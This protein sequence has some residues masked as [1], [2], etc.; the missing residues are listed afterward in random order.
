MA[1]PVSLS[2]V[3]SHVPAAVH[4][5][6]PEEPAQ[7]AD[8]PIAE[9]RQADPVEG[10]WRVIT[11]ASGRTPASLLQSM[12]KRASGQASSSSSRVGIGSVPS[13]RAVATS[14][15]V[16]SETRSGR[17]HS[18]RQVVVVEGDDHA[19]GGHP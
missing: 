17:P 12:L 6:W 18:A 9:R 16:S 10:A 7:G 5:R 19:V 11:S 8:P 4:S 15:A 2:S 3:S 1:N 13:T 14:A